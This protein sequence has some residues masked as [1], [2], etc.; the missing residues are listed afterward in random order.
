M[1]KLLRLAAGCPKPTLMVMSLRAFQSRG[2]T[3]I[4]W[5]RSR[6]VCA[7]EPCLR[8]RACSSEN[9]VADAGLGED[10]RDHL[11]LGLGGIEHSGWAMVATWFCRALGVDPPAP[12]A[13]RRCAIR[14]WHLDIAATGTRDRRCRDAR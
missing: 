14:A 3:V 4:H 1:R 8:T 7:C 13:T 12:A 10:A 5:L 2:S 9:R 11:H 6:T